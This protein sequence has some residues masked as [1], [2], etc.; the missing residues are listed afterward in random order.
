MSTKQI[1][2]DDAQRRVAEHTHG[3]LLVMAPV[4]TGKTLVLAERVANAIASGIQPERMLGLT[5][6]NR[7]CNEIRKRARG[8]YPESAELVRIQTFHG[9][10]AS[11]LRTEAKYIGLPCDFVIH[12]E[13]DCV[14]VIKELVD[15]TADSYP[16]RAQLLDDFVSILHPLQKNP[17]IE[18]TSLVGFLPSHCFEFLRGYSLDLS[19]CKDHLK[20]VSEFLYLILRFFALEVF[21][22]FFFELL[23]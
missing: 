1:R 4:G 2:L 3:G 16:G 6:T 7:A 11:M 19:E 8:R 12:D 23:V 22:Q 13:I 17:L 18:R 15:R 20:H 10:C 21:S 5:F 14:E 9:L